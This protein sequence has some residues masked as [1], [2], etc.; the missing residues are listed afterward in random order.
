MTTDGGDVGEIQMRT[1]SM[2][3]CAEIYPEGFR[4]CARSRGVCVDQ[5]GA[6]GSPGVT[7]IIDGRRQHWQGPMS[8]FASLV[9][10]QVGKEEGKWRGRR[11]D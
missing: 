3:F 5:K 1:D 11:G 4:R 9:E 6:A 2:I 8:E 10:S 7:G